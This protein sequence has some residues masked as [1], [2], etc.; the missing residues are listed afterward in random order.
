MPLLVFQNYV[1]FSK[2]PFFHSLLFSVAYVIIVCIGSYTVEL[3]EDS[4]YD[5]RIKLKR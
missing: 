3:N 5:W 4:L 1:Y 2:T